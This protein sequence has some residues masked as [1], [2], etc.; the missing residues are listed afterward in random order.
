MVQ[1]PTTVYG[2]SGTTLTFT[3]APASGDLIE[4]RKFTTTTTVTA[5]ADADGDT[6]VQ[7]EESSDEDKI[8]FDTAGT[9]RAFI[10]A[11]G[12]T[13][14]AQGDVRFG[15]SDSPKLCGTT[16]LSNS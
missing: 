3:T 7:V 6:Q 14:N 13:V 1:Q 9:E 4:V 11:G 15:D 5:I 12:I 10:D 8:R 16:G 2:I